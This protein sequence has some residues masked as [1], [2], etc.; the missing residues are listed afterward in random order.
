MT[1]AISPQTTFNGAIPGEGPKCVPY[2][3]DFNTGTT[4][5]TDLEVI[6]QNGQISGV[7]SVYIDNLDNAAPVSLTL[8]VS[9]QRIV[10]PANAE[11]YFLILATSSMQFKWFCA[12][13]VVVPIQ[14]MNFPVAVS[15]WPMG[16]N[17]SNVPDA[18]TDNTTIYGIKN[19]N[20]TA[21]PIQA[22]APNDA[23]YYVRHGNAWSSL[24]NSIGPFLPLSANSG[25][26]L[27]GT[28]YTQATA[29]LSDIY[30]FL[31]ANGGHYPLT[32]GIS[33]VET[34]ARR[35]GLF[36]TIASGN[37][38]TFGI[39]L[40]STSGVATT[41]PL[42]MDWATGNATFLAKIIGSGTNLIPSLTSA[43]DL[44]SGFASGNGVSY[45]IIGGARTV[46]FTTTA[47]TVNTVN[48]FD[49]ASP[50][51]VI[52]TIYSGG[53]I[54]AGSRTVTAATTT[55]A[56]DKTIR[57][58]ATSAPISQTL[59]TPTVNQEMM[60]AKISTNTNALTIVA[61]SGDTING[62]ANYVMNA[63]ARQSINVHYDVSAKDWT[64]G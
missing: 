42:Q 24:G 49:I 1:S 51:A 15:V 40:F 8:S 54:S 7:Q 46:S 60:L 36:S 14:Y 33:G 11:G 41:Q 30:T 35:W 44:T 37:V 29:G 5:N 56:N 3:L 32:S 59:H 53:G 25:K 9:N 10:C 63:A 50:G 16:G 22:D 6:K 38:T 61:N 55:T 18:P 20:W 39:Q 45:V 17:S 23:N 47:M 64:V 34:V 12:N 21:V 43:L 4:L 13:P 57:F 19:L 28:L 58:D 48:G 27:T 31:A 26:P 62:A 52:R 2:N